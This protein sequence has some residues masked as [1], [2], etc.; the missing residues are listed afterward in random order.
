MRKILIALLLIVVAAAAW[1]IYV[2]VQIENALDN[3]YT[4]HAGG[5][6]IHHAV[7]R[8]ERERYGAHATSVLQVSGKGLDFEVELEHRIDHRLLGAAVQTRT[9][10]GRSAG[11]IPAPWAAVLAQARPRADSWLGLGGGISSRLSSRPVLISGDAD[12]EAEPLPFRLHLGAGQ[13]GVAYSPERM[14]LS[15]DT[16]LLDLAEGQERLLLEQLYF[17][18]VVHPEPDGG[19]GSLPDYDIG[20]GSQLISLTLGNREVL[21]LE[22]LQMSSNQNSAAD[23]LDSLWRVRAEELRSVGLELETLDLQL[24]A[25]RWHRPTLLRFMEDLEGV[26]A[27]ALAA[28]LQTGLLL[29]MLLDGLQRMIEHDPLLRGHLRLNSEPGKHVRLNM[30]LGLSGDA[31]DFAARPLES[32]ALDLDLEAG[33]ALLEEVAALLETET[34]LE[35]T[36]AMDL[37]TLLELAVSEEWAQIENGILSSRLRMEDGRLL[38]N[39]RDQTV[40][41]LALV[42]GFARGMF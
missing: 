26:R 5:L 38:I 21:G 12:P 16:D 22:S 35:A 20:L 23:R 33:L 10:P 2:G 28:D 9:V 25:L 34:G 39:G 15:F 27:M 14:V 4:G 30:D 1:P 42:F 32:I 31:E 6:R 36:E 40:L 11:R 19:Y 24:T 29:G 17:G 37:E 3:A 18:L 41:L 7:T 8:Y 13:G